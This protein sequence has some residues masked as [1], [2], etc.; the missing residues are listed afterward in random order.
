[1]PFQL[2]FG[3][4]G[5]VPGATYLMF[6]VVSPARVGHFAYPN[7]PKASHE[8]NGLILRRYGVLLSLRQ[9]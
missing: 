6:A 9:Y 4:L 1:M 7:T 8:C 5:D 2:T 3:T